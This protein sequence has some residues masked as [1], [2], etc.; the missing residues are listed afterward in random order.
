MPEM[1][2]R[3]GL[4]LGVKLFTLTMDKKSEPLTLPEDSVLQDY[5]CRFV[6][7]YTVTVAF[8]ALCP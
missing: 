6:A 1:V 3:G 8:G 7:G 5:H 2:T 4:D